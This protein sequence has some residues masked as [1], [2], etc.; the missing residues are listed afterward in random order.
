MNFDS[1]FSKTNHIYTPTKAVSSCHHIRQWQEEK[2]K[3]MLSHSPC[4]H[5][6]FLSSC[7]S[8]SH[9]LRTD[10]LI[11]RLEFF[12]LYAC[13][14]YVEWETEWQ[15]MVWERRMNES[16]MEVKEQQHDGHVV[17]LS[18]LNFLKVLPPNISTLYYRIYFYLDIFILE[19]FLRFLL[20]W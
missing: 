18:G 3:K 10:V 8:L 11:W 5:L 14:G 12:F 13:Y 20:A 4:I 17:S 15:F 9:L 2:N 19:L 16:E 7:V 6:L 1:F